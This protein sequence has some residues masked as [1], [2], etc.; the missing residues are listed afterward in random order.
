MPLKISRI[1]RPTD[2]EMLRYLNGYA[3]ENPMAVHSILHEPGQIEFFV[4][5][6]SETG[7]IVGHISNSQTPG[8]VFV[9]IAGDN[10]AVVRALIP[11]APHRGA[12]ITRRRS[13]PRSSRAK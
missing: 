3:L 8:V 11:L 13:S 9:S 1:D 2:P 7:R 12:V 4:C 10:A 6:D 5:R